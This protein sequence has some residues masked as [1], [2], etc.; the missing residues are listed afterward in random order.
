MTSLPFIPLLSPKALSEFSPAEF[1]SYVQSL[2]AV[3]ESRKK[4]PPKEFSWSLTKKG[5]LSIRVKRT[6]KFLRPA[7][8][9]QIARESGIEERLV[10][11]KVASPKSG[12]KILR[13]KKGLPWPSGE[14]K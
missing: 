13:D 8:I 11:I 10:W 7:E 6:P 5:V 14:K 4:T 9:T 12:I 3:P 2:K 1:R